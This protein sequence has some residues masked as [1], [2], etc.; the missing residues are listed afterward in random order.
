MANIIRKNEGGIMPSHATFDP[1]DVMRELLSFE[2]LRQMFGGGLVPRPMREFIPQ[3]EVRE[4]GDAYIFKADLPGVRDAD[5]DIN[6]SQN[7]LT[8]SGRREMEQRDE[9]D[10]YYAVERSY[11]S[12]NRS[13]TLPADIDDAHIEAELRDGVLTLKVPKRPEQ[14]PKKVQIKSGG[15]GGAKTA[16]ADSA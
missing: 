7:R 8:I 6:I 16:K 9:S 3:F 13:F 12:F 5:L 14:Q 11:G 4:T 1:F 10:R 2:P 15:G